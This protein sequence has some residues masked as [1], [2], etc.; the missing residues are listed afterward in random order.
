MEIR[1]NSIPNSGSDISFPIPDSMYPENNEIV[2]VKVDKTSRSESSADLFNLNWR[3]NRPMELRLKVST[4]RL[5]VIV[6]SNF[7]PLPVSINLPSSDPYWI[8]WKS[9]RGC[10]PHSQLT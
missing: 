9:V 8:S 10:F 3:P 5:C 4:N 2:N 6:V 7:L 1:W